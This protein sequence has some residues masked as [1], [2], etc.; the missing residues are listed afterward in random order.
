MILFDDEKLAKTGTNASFTPT[1]VP[2]KL[3]R[4]LRRAC[5]S[6]ALKKLS[7]SEARP[8]DSIDSSH[9]TAI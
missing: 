2:A 9:H 5:S 1:A 7:V 6:G 8:S 4:D 3:T